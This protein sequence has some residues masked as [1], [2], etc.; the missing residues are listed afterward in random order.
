LRSTCEEM[1]LSA[2]KEEMRVKL[3]AQCIQAVRK[4]GSPQEFVRTFKYR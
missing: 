4:N 3:H 1:V 2:L